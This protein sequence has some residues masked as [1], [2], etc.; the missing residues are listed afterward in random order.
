[1]EL[2]ARQAGSHHHQG[3]GRSEAM[4]DE[5][6]ECLWAVVG[7]GCLVCSL[8]V[9]PS[10]WLWWWWGMVVACLEDV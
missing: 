6:D 2:K 9:S 5:V 3:M 8:N 7:V 1:M 10:A 4:W